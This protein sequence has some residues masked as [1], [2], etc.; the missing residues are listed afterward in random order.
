MS[1]T[2]NIYIVVC[3]MVYHKAHKHNFNV[4][5]IILSKHK[6]KNRENFRFYMKRCEFS[7]V[8]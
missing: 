3:E 1:K 4:I 6:K 8:V 2:E 7:F 5:Y